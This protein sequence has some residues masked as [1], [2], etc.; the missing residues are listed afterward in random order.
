MQVI[1]ALR[2]LPNFHQIN[3]MLDG[4]PAH[5]SEERLPNFSE[6]IAAFS[7][8]HP[9]PIDDAIQP[10]ISHEPVKRVPAKTAKN[11]EDSPAVSSPDLDE[12][13][14]SGSSD[15]ESDESDFRSDSVGGLDSGDLL[16]LI[17]WLGLPVH[18]IDNAIQPKVSQGPVKPAKN[19]K[20]RE[21]PGQTSFPDQSLYDSADTSSYKS[22]THENDD[23]QTMAS[24]RTRMN[25]EAMTTQGTTLAWDEDARS[26]CAH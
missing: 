15:N 16:D 18:L 14:E 3:F 13:D 6:T 24:W 20:H 19:V 12:D 25:L 8:I 1:P 21:H 4:A 7:R 5:F 22:E 11:E 9:S 17:G 10:K 2:A 23:R 26:V